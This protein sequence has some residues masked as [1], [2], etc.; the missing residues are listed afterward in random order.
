MC[1][2]LFYRSD[3]FTGMLTANF[4]E[5]AERSTKLNMS[6]EAVEQLVKFIYG[7]DIDIDLSFCQSDDD[8]LKELLIHGGV[9]G[10]DCLQK[11]AEKRLGEHLWKHGN[12]VDLDCINLLD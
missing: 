5:R 9:Y 11:A 10:L 8:V 3:F 4:K 1:N 12:D 2:Y 7:F 6:S